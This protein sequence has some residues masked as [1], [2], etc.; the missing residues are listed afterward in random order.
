MHQVSEVKQVIKEE[1]IAAGQAI[2]YSEPE[3]Q[4]MSR[5]GDMCVVA[6]TDQWYINYGEDEWREATRHIPCPHF[7]AFILKLHDMRPKI[8]S[9]ETCHQSI[10]YR[11]E[12]MMLHEMFFEPAV[13]LHLLSSS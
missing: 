13:T 3:R 6:L 8:L 12:W 2:V 5:S 1:M 4:V 10:V 11:Q 9:L 7:C